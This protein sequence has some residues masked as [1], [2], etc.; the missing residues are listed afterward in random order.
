MR[1]THSDTHAHTYTFFLI[2]NYRF[3]A[4]WEGKYEFSTFPNA[5]LYTFSLHM[6]RGS[7]QIPYNILSF[8]IPQYSLKPNFPIILRPT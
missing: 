4:L 8:Q 6:G 1:N 2:L 7:F 3:R 5:L